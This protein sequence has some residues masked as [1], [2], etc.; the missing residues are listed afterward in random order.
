MKAAFKRK[1]AKDRKQL[2]LDALYITSDR[3][4]YMNTSFTKLQFVLHGKVTCHKALMMILD[5]SENYLRAVV[6]MWKDGAVRVFRYDL[7]PS[8]VNTSYVQAITGF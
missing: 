6:N 1:D 3:K 5:F 8:N 2:L 7:K 4:K